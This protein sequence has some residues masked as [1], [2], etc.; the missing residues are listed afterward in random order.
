MISIFSGLLAFL[1]CLGLD[2]LLF[3]LPLRG[4]STDLDSYTA[5]ATAQLRIVSMEHLM[6]VSST[7]GANIDLF[8][9][10]KVQLALEAAEPAVSEVK[11]NNF[12]EERV[13]SETKRSEC[14]YS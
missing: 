5:H 2:G 6:V 8:E 7:E 14:E 4:G 10:V 13:C 12:L 1:F 3:L 11:R 9:P